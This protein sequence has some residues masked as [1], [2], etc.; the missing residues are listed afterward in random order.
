MTSIQ[1][2]FHA[3][4][5]E[6]VEL[7]SRWAPAHELGLVIEQF[8]PLTLAVVIGST[9]LAASCADL[10][11]VDRMWMCPAGAL[12][13]FENNAGDDAAWMRDCLSVRIGRRDDS[14]VRESWLGGVTENDALLRTWRAVIRKAKTEMHKGAVIRN[15]VTGAV[16][17]LPA[18]R[19]TVGA[20]ELAERGVKMLA[21]AGW[22]E[23]EFDDVAV[24]R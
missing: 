7:V 12:D 16:G 2:G 17:P 23:Y 21:G 9:G 6:L 10:D 20:H 1:F 24:S 18:H 3:E 4:P 19:H 8:F 15:P 11:R 22:N 5:N 13:V 14:G